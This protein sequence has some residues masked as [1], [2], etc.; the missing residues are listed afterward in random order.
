MDRDE[1]HDIYR[2]WRAIADSYDE[3]RVLVGEIWLPDAERFARYLRPDEL[4]TAFNFDFLSCPWEPRACAR[5]STPRS[6]RTPRSTRRPTWVLS[7]HDVTRPVTRYGRDDTSFSF[8]AKRAGT[9]TDLARGTRRARA[10]ALLDDGA[11]RAR[12]TS[13]R[14]TS[15]ACPRSRT[16]PTTCAQDP[17]Y[18]P[19]RRRR[20]RPR[21]LPRADPLVGRP[22]RRTASAPTVRRTVARPARRLGAADGRGRR[23]SDP[24]RCSTSTAQASGCAG[25]ALGRRMAALDWL[26]TR[27]RRARVRAR[28]RVHLPH[29]LRS[30]RRSRCPA[31]AEISASQAASSKEVQC[32][33]DT[34]VWLRQADGQSARGHQERKDDEVHA[35]GH[36]RGR[37]DCRLARSLRD[38]SRRAS[39]RRRRRSRSAS[40]R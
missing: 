18:A 8:E 6:R 25:G 15:S 14:A 35:F 39:V 3:P 19:L 17:M 33:Q 10:A 32:P 11:A 27:R 12:C 13:T 9:P 24:A 29:E 36:G 1:L 38:R 30:G 28:R 20:S 37:G 26:S 5:R 23:S 7:N 34:T 2:G 22:S 16:S 40:R 21:R 31:G 4:H